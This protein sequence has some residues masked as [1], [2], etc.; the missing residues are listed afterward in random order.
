MIILKNAPYLDINRS[1]KMDRAFLNEVAN[2]IIDRV[3]APPEIAYSGIFAAMS[4]CCQHHV[5]VNCP[6]GGRSPTSVYLMTSAESGDRKTAVENQLFK[7]IFEIDSRNRLGS[8]ASE[9]EYD[10]E[11]IIWRAKRKQ[12]ERDFGNALKE[13]IA[14]EEIENCLAQ[15]IDSE[16]EKQKAT[17]FL[18]R[19]VSVSALQK[20]MA[21][22]NANA[23][24]ILSESMGLFSSRNADSLPTLSAI[25]DG[26]PI[27]VERA[28]KPS[29][30]VASPRLTISLMMQPGV[31]RGYLGKHSGVARLSGLLARFLVVE[32]KSRQG[33]RQIHPTE[34][35]LPKKDD[36]LKQFHAR[37][38]ELLSNIPK[39]RE[40]LSFSPAAQQIWVE[41]YNNV[42]DQLGQYGC[43][44]DIRDCASKI[45]NNLSR[46]AALIHY[47]CG[48]P[49]DIDFESAVCARDHCIKYLLNFKRLFGVLSHEE[50][51]RQDAIRLNTFLADKATLGMTQG[52]WGLAK[53]LNGQ[54]Y[55]EKSHLEK[56]GPLRPVAQ[57]DAA[58]E[59]LSF[60]Q[61]VGF[62]QLARKKVVL[63]HPHVSAQIPRYDP[64]SRYQ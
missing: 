3:K 14:T 1:I 30:Y 33:M 44:S 4:I 25:W 6:G 21:E 53:N 48:K 55:F 32:P 26:R 20:G 17:R 43:F 34:V 60:W 27:D 35:G 38:L 9:K 47:F 39:D 36:A 5:D 31:L 41:F 10:R 29:W 63:F 40:L 57:L 23:A 16:P 56:S 52:F 22:N 18:Y 46:L 51:T 12:L 2:E 37:E 49:G 62:N 61:V 19:D 24:L 28:N 50:S 7:P 58:L 59:L 15:I 11:Q 13:S 8:I 42:E 54:V 64:N 45:A